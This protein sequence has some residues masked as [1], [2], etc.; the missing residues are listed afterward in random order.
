MSATA[1]R[2]TAIRRLG[3]A[4]ATAIVTVAVA[5]APV[6]ARQVVDPMTLNP[7]PPD[8]FNAT[9][10][11]QGTQIVCDLAFADPDYAGEP[12][13]IMCDGTELLASGSRSVVGKRFYDGDGNLLRRHF[14]EDLGGTLTNPDSGVVLLWTGHN[15]IFHELATPGDLDSGTIK[16]TGL[17]NR[18]LTEAGRTVLTDTGTILLQAGTDETLRSSHHRPFDDYFVNGN[19][20]ALQAICDAID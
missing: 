6:L 2:A 19:A 18:I 10:Y 4:F 3:A 16:I 9:C 7:A 14:R 5:A 20:D 17:A 15:T 11:E 8:F 12:S 13:G 1:F